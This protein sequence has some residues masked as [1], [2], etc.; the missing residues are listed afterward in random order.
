MK[1]KTSQ[2]PLELCCVDSLLNLELPEESGRKMTEDDLGS[3]CFEFL[4]GG[5]HSDDDEIKEEDL[6]K[7]PY[8][9]WSGGTKKTSIWPFCLPHAV[10][11]DAI[12]I[13]WDSKVWKEPMVFKL[14]RFLN[15]EDGYL[16]FVP[17]LF[18]NCFKFKSHIN[19]YPERRQYMRH[20]D[21]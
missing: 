6:K 5:S 9:N 1:K 12:K 18:I 10:T 3:L 13:G 15:E 16:K 4:N 8:L 17:I 20:R 2:D 11:Q 19:S 21:K 7:L 14:E